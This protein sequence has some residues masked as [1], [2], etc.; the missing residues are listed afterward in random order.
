MKPWSKVLV[1]AGLV[2]IATLPQTASAFWW[3]S[4]WYGGGW[5]NNYVHDPAY[6]FG[7][8]QL[9]QYIRDLHRRGPAY[10]QWRQHRRY[11]W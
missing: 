7:T 2:A 9:R 6:R 1:A 3:G 10:A 8:P 11:W 5:R 4:P